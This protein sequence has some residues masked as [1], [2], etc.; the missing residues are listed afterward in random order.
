MYS[1]IPTEHLHDGADEMTGMS[2]IAYQYM[3]STCNTAAVRGPFQLPSRVS[4]QMRIRP[5]DLGVSS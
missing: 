4:Q 5:I 1:E 3:I 2:P